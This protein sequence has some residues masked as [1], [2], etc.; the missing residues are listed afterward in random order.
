MNLRLAT[1]NI[2]G[3]NDIYKQ[4]KLISELKYNK[5]D[6]IF[7]QETHIDTVKKHKILACYGR[8]KLRGI[9]VQIFQPELLFYSIQIYQFILLNHQKTGEAEF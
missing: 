1:L 2:R 6:I 3:L 8:A 5:F 4:R 7:L 9:L